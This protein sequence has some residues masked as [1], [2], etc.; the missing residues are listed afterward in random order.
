MGHVN[1]A[2]PPPHGFTQIARH[3]LGDTGKVV[4]LG[5]LVAK[6]WAHKYTCIVYSLTLHDSIPVKLGREVLPQKV[7]ALGRGEFSMLL[8]SAPPPLLASTNG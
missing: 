3:K 1:H 4:G 8:L 5:K 2:L 6:I 7:E